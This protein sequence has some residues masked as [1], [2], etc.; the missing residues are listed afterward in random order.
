M[1]RLPETEQVH[2]VAAQLADAPL[3]TLLEAMLSD[4][5]R[6]HGAVRLALPGIIVLAESIAHAYASGG[7][8]ILTGAGTSGRLAA[9]EAAECP[10][11]F[12]TD[13]A[14][15]VALVAGGAD[16]LQRSVEGAEDDSAAAA[17]RIA[18]IGIGPGDLV[19]GLSASGATPFVRGAV[20][21]AGERGAETVAIVNTPDAP[22][23]ALARRAIVLPTG[24]EFVAGS[25][26]LKAGSAQKLA[27][28]L[29]TTGAMTILGRVRAGRM[30]AVQ[31][32]NA[33]LRARAVRTIQAL[34]GVD[35]AKAESQLEAAG[36][37]VFAVLRDAPAAPLAPRR[38]TPAVVLRT[39]GPNDAP[40]VLAL[41]E[42]PAVVAT[43]APFGRI[44]GEALF[45]EWLA[46]P[47]LMLA[48][49]T[50]GRLIGVALV[51][52]RRALLRE[53]VADIG[54]VAVHPRFTGQGIGEQLVRH[55]LAWAADAG[56]LRVELRVWPDN[57]AAVRLYSRLGFE[58][59]GRIRGH[60]I[61]DGRVRDALLMA[62]VDPRLGA[63]HEGEEVDT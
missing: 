39:L 27:L 30:I 12:G 41:A 2:P 49:F 54:Y 26:R 34:T 46:R 56:F 8:I 22:L 20:S 21:A 4:H 55:V 16:A 40:S 50:D 13:P 53:H 37:D 38:E 57:V 23:A 62:W 1:I 59:E 51:E 19:V 60:A 11:T 42:D 52:T 33:K 15:I 63:G 3:P 29:A 10:P 44:G 43:T 9:L 48:A 45:R 6:V 5:A 7:R 31:P 17:E 61:V 14:R 36:G 32:T 28:N 35:A 58:I 25:T 24:P 47:G 18:A